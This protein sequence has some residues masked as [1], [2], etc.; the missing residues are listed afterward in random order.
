MN[1]EL[2]WGDII[3]DFQKNYPNASMLMNDCGPY[4]P[5]TLIIWMKTGV[6]MLYNYNTKE[7]SVKESE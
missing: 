6:E 7:L 1:G 2:T 4:S 3:R 5:F